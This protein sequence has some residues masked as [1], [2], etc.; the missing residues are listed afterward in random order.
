MYI[1]FLSFSSIS[2]FDPQIPLWWSLLPRINNFVN[3]DP[4]SRHRLYL[5]FIERL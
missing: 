2:S 3:L 4:F 5:L 1:H